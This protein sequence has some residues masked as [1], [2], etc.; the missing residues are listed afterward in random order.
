M[1]LLFP[2]P[3]VYDGDDAQFLRRDGARF[4]PALA[5][6]GDRG[7][8]IILAESDASLRPSPPDL[9]VVP[10]RGWCDPDFWKSFHADGALCYF[11][12]SAR[13]FLPVVRAMR[14]AGLRL[15]LKAD[16][17]FGLH[18][19]P[20]HASIWFRKCYWVA[21]QNH[22]P[23][24][25][26]AKAALDM[27]KW[28]R[29]FDTGT[30]IPYLESFD[31]LTVE[32]P[33]AAENTRDWLLRHGRPDLADRV[34]FLPH[35]VPD[36]FAFDPARDAKENLVLAVAQ[37]W[38]NP[39]KGGAILAGALERFLA[40]HPDWRATVVG[41]NADLVAAAAPH[42]SDRIDRRP[43]LESADLLPLYRSAKIFLTASGSE[44][45]PIVA[46]E[47]LACGCSVVFPPE[48]LHLSWIRDAGLGTMSARRSPDSL[49]PSLDAEAAIWN[50][51]P[52]RVPAHPLPPLRASEILPRLFSV[53]PTT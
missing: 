41:A 3:V 13:R 53:T 15:A 5:S 10:F 24:A 11:G 47:A 2:T 8:K 52:R 33:L 32:S 18:R 16:S 12:F 14:A 4:L 21:R 22:I 23:A 40:N 46:F 25:A 1:T 19:F 49:A 30:M 35:P 39:R 20:G 45:G 34:V 38:R 17:S 51:S 37:D 26:L 42:V 31:A 6:R 36:G 7:I 48:L 29:G 28:I 50:S 9:L 44:S 43:P 27:A